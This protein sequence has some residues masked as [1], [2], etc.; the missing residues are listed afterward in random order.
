MC[1]SIHDVQ[2]H[3]D[4]AK[5][6]LDRGANPLAENEAGDTPDDLSSDSECIRLI[7]RASHKVGR[8]YTNVV[9]LEVGTKISGLYKSN[10]NWYG[11]VIAG[12]QEDG[13]FVVDWDDGDKKDKVKPLS[14]LAVRLSSVR[15]GSN[16]SPR[17][18]IPRSLSLSLSLSFYLSL[19]LCVFVC[20]SLSFSSLS[21][22]HTHTHTQS[23]NISDAMVFTACL[24]VHWSPSWRHC[25]GIEYKRGRGIHCIS[26]HCWR[27]RGQRRSCL[28]AL[29]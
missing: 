12:K 14:E 17:L 19:S 3:G 22:S 8:E 29:L 23:L 21:L 13:M 6:L 10:G 24:V 27:G 16:I 26:R 1:K 9:S 7:S 25:E 20:A 18:L 15:V 5:A 11:G 28:Q 2:G 4:V